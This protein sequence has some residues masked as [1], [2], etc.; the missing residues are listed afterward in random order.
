MLKYG[1]GL[2]VNVVMLTF[3][4]RRGWAMRSQFLI[5][6]D[7]ESLRRDYRNYIDEFERKAP[8]SQG[9]D[10][11]EIEIV[12][13]GCAA[14]AKAR[15]LDPARKTQPFDVMLLDLLLPQRPGEIPS[16]RHGLE[17]GKMAQDLGTVKWTVIVSGALEDISVGDTMEWFDLAATGFIRKSGLI[18]QDIQNAIVQARHATGH[19]ASEFHSC[20]LSYSSQDQK[21]ATRL[22]VDL[23]SKAVRCWFA[24]KNLKIGD[25][26]RTRIHESIS[27]YDKLLVI[28]SK[29]AIQSPW[30]ED[31]VETALARERRE[32]REILFPVTL[33]D[34]V[35]TATQAWAQSLRDTRHIGD[36][37]NWKNAASYRNSLDRLLRDLKAKGKAESAWQ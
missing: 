14:D 28:I 32:Q 7:D 29:N 10:T 21:F 33:D 6:E 25:K 22:Y 9:T 27:L 11:F 19:D 5:V 1:I 13:A 23:Q 15:L 31:E 36:F 20:F 17:V 3:E 18:K 35:I 4:A 24:P 30:V 34:G 12:D 26:F 37:R 16:I 2:R 8:L